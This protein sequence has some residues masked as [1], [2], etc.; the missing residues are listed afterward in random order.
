MEMER[1]HADC[2]HVYQSLRQWQ[3]VAC[4]PSAVPVMATGGALGFANECFLALLMVSFALKKPFGNLI[5]TLRD[6]AMLTGQSSG[7][8]S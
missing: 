6:V 1:W 4:R 7:D 2:P 8:V 5:G 3:V